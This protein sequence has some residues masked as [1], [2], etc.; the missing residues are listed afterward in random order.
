MMVP[1]I[2]AFLYLFSC[3]HD[4]DP[5]SSV[6]DWRESSPEAHNLNPD[7]L[8]NLAGRIEAGVYGE[9]HSLLIVRHGYLVYER[10]FRGNRADKLPRCT[11]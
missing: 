8:A 7:T 9:I 10:Y 1:L 4:L 6:D 11:R 3:S 2:L 5:N